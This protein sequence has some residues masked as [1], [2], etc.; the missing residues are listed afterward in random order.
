MIPQVYHDFCMHYAPW[1]YII[2]AELTSNAAVGQKDVVVSDGSAFEA[3]MP[4]QIK[5][6]VHCEW[7][8]VASVFG[9]TVTM[10]KN[11]AY[12]YYTSKGSLVDHPD[13]TFGKG[14][15]PAAFAVEYL[16]DSYSAGQFSTVKSEILTK[17]L[18][19]SDWLLTQQCTDSQKAAYGG[20]KSAEGSTQYWSIDAGRVIPA[21]LKAYKLSDDLAYRE[22]A[23][24]CGYTFLYNMQHGPLAAGV[25]GGYYGGLAQ[26][27]DADDEYGTVMMTEDLYC[28][29]GLSMLTTIDSTNADRYQAIMAD[30]VTFYR[31]G[32]EG[33]WLYFQ[34]PPDGTGEWFR[35]GL[36]NSEVYDDPISFALLGLYTYE[37]WSASCQ[38]VYNFVQG[39]KASGS[40]PGYIP[41]LCWPGY[42]DVISR[43]PTCNYYDDVTIGILW[44][45]RKE[46]DPPSYKLAHDLA[47]KYA[48]E[49]L[50]WGP[51]FADYSPVVAA[52]AIA[53]VSWIG[54]MFLNY[55]EPTSQFARILKSKGELVLLFPVVEA[56]DTTSYGKP[57]DL[58]AVFSPL[59]AEQVL[60]E[61]GYYLNDYL[62]VYT[63]LPVRVHDKIRRQGVDY[64]V[65]TVTPY[66]Y[67][68]QRCYF[69]STLRRL[70]V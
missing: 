22:A 42:I 67:A 50:N 48:D 36:N 65:Q 39:I 38:R 19:L 6:S 15:F 12:T 44:K 29:I 13:L 43:F 63:F 24:L 18:E 17:V 26:Y 69:K 60:L 57:W 66:T 40:Y 61:A 47:E 10:V 3:G 27:V 20:F 25:V 59:K 58:L 8:E 33:L 41:D 34:P 62:A 30:M 14:A 16:F 4:V 35:I 31:E 23:K 2:P 68:N 56:A 28:L 52:K 11:L 1:Y 21:L 32:F 45:I 37:G 7:N 9:N 46:Y 51:L 70:I 49:F 5:D 53:N 64:E 55:T 54:R